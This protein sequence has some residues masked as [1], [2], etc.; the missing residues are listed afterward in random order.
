MLYGNWRTQ[1]TQ[2]L[3]QLEELCRYKQ[4]PKERTDLRM[5]RRAIRR[6]LKLPEHEPMP[7]MTE[8]RA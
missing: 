8:E 2:V 4:S 7:E 5:A 3:G 1:L 6:V